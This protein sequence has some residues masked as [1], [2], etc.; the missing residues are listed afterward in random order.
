LCLG[1]GNVRSVH[2]DPFK[3]ATNGQ[4]DPGEWTNNPNL[5]PTVSSQSFAYDPATGAGG[6]TLYVEQ[7]FTQVQAAVAGG[8]QPDT[9]FLMY[10]INN[11]PTHGR[12][13]PTAA[14]FFDVFFQVPSDGNDYLARIFGDS[15]TSHQDFLLYEKP[16]GTVSPTTAD[17]SFDVS[18][19]ALWTLLNPPGGQDDPDFT[20]AKP[21]GVVGFNGTTA[22]GSN[23][24]P[25]H[26]E[27]EFQLS[28]N[29]TPPQ[30]SNGPTGL[31]DP[32]DPA[33]WSGSGDPGGG[34]PP[35]TSGVFKLNPNGTTSVT[36]AFGPN[37][38][39]LLQPLAVAAPEPASLTLCALAGLCLAGYQGWRR[40][41]RR[42]TA[43]S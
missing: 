11:N 14:N 16:T 26:V 39:P 32:N 5:I 10:D 4:F 40:A 18:D 20:L 3:H 38:D 8:G 19:T 17:G 27:V 9:L 33:F 37:G 1:L 13:Q 21:V 15:T 34:D 12:A 42:L 6:A 28:I 41:G 7:G 31:Y 25:N 43:R 29:T 22:D 30:S 35:F 24:A 36:P 23:T 2:A